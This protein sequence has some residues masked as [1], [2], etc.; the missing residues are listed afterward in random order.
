MNRIRSRWLLPASLLLSSTLALGISF[1]V[2]PTRADDGVDKRVLEDE[3]KRIA[4]IEKVKPT[5][6]R[7]LFAEIR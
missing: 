3:A 6:V 5:V 1:W 2:S 7:H 4:A